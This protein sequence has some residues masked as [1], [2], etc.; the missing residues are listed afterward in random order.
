MP[1]V[2]F[3]PG[4]LGCRMIRAD[5]FELWPPVGQE[6]PIDVDTRV[7]GLLD[8][9]TRHGDIIDRI[10]DPVVNTPAYGPVLDALANM[11]GVTSHPFA[12]DWRKDLTST[13][14]DAL[15]ALLDTLPSGQR[16]I[17]VAHSMGGLLVR[18]MLE[19][20][21]YTNR[22]WF[23]SI[24]QFISICVPH[25]GAPLCLFRIL[26]L[27]GVEPVVF[28]PSACHQ[29]GSQPELYPAGHQLLPAPS[30]EPVTFNDGTNSTVRNAF[31]QISSIGL[32]AS[33]RLHAVL[34]R[35]QRPQAISY[36]LAYGSGLG[37]VSSIKAVAVGDKKPMELSA[38]GDTT[39]PVWS[40]C[41]SKAI[42]A[43][44]G[45]FEEEVPFDGATH[46]GIL[47]DK[48]FLN[49]LQIW[50]TGATVPIA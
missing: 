19:S 18:W 23:N 20:G 15:A 13:L 40:A 34:D 47:G 35:F 25:L 30:V 31:P 7:H 6:E 37:T 33:D 22:R 24:D 27:A 11:Q 12:Y 29:L 38:P 4:I 3:V 46:T 48:R 9:A 10:H 50:L 1:H 42:K 14:P 49:Q 41:P 44:A 45:C 21:H 2:V 16:V 43:A 32:D 39:V 8:A 28:G 5:G 26:G 17:L 36:Q